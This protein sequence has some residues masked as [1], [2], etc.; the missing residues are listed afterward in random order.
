MVTTW[1]TPADYIFTLSE[2]SSSS[3]IVGSRSTVRSALWA[4]NGVTWLARRLH[5]C[6]SST[7]VPDTCPSRT[8]LHPFPGP[9][10][11]SWPD[12]PHN[13][14]LF[15]T[16]GP[17]AY[18]ASLQRPIV[19]VVAELGRPGRVRLGEQAPDLDGVVGLLGERFGVLN[20]CLWPLYMYAGSLA[21]EG[22]ASGRWAGRA[23]AADQAGRDG[24]AAAFA[25]SF[26]S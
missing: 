7:D 6:S 20:S 8:R 1:P 24:E 10:R 19:E 9:R 2:C 25:W 15:G 14:P 23:G 11:A 21:R 3:G 26:G 5:S 18:T 4:M 16:R 22:M 17:W 13:R 12:V